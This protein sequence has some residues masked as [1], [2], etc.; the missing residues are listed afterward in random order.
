MDILIVTGGNIDYEWGKKWLNNRHYDY[1]IAADRGAYHSYR[2]E[3]IPN[4]IIGDFD[5]VGNI[6]YEKL[7]SDNED[8]VE[9]YPCEKDDTDTGLAVVKAIA[10]INDN[11]EYDTKD[12]TITILGATGTRL[13]HVFGNIG[14]LDKIAEAGIHGT[15]IDEHNCINVLYAGKTMNI[16]KNDQYGYFVSILPYG[17]DISGL[18]L[19]GFKYSLS[20]EYVKNNSSLCISNEIESEVASISLETGKALIIQALD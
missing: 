14:N 11:D 19:N 20:K 5:S 10:I 12:N 15:I 16:G 7:I 3:V 9:R 8:I 18:S 2:M 13:D 1:V 4:K 6:N 17:G